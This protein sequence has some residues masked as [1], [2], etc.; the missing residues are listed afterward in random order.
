[1]PRAT[2][3]SRPTDWPSP[4][5]RS[6]GSKPAE[7]TPRSDRIAEALDV[8]DATGDP[9]TVGLARTAAAELAAFHGHL[10]VAAAHLDHGQQVLEAARG[11]W[12]SAFAA[13]MRCYAHGLAGRHA[14]AEREIVTAIELFRSV[15]DV[16]SVV[17]SLDQ[18]IREQQSMARYEAIEASVRE[19]REV[20][21]GAWPARLARAR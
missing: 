19:A 5:T 13:Q 4:G 12:T 21:R 20:E 11:P 6:S 18:L 8:A 9:A 3:P 16:C 2:P 7:S 10:D 14:D 15:G 1:M 17:T